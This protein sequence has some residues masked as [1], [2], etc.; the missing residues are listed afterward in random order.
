MLK[1]VEI[2]EYIDLD[3]ETA[4]I[5]ADFSKISKKIKPESPK[6]NPIELD[7]LPHR[8][9]TEER[10]NSQPVNQ[11]WRKYSGLNTKSI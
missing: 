5:T 10:L 11:P 4:E 3:S 2:T 6:N 8:R 9:L 7:S 1:R